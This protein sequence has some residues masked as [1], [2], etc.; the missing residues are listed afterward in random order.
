MDTKNLVSIA[1]MKL[2]ATVR[3]PYTVP[4]SG[5]LETGTIYSVSNTR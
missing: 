5:S 4:I 2:L 3:G 1:P